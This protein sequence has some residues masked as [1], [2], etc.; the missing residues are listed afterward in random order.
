[1]SDEQEAVPMTFA[2]WPRPE[3]DRDTDTHSASTVVMRQIGFGMNP[4]IM[5]APTM[6]EETDTVGFHVDL[7]EINLTDAHGVLSMVVAALAQHLGGEHPDLSE[8]DYEE[9]N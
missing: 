7:S 2:F 1:M 4:F 3:P 8:V 9:K 5:V 6:D